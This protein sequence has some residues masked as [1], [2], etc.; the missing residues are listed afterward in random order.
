MCIG[1]KSHTLLIKSYPIIGYEYVILGYDFSSIVQFRLQLCNG[2]TS[3]PKNHTPLPPY[4]DTSS[5]TASGPSSPNSLQK[6][7]H[8]IFQGVIFTL[9]TY[10]I[11]Y[12]CGGQTISGYN[13]SQAGYD[14]VLPTHTLFAG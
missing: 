12:S 11:T 6:G 10:D 2:K 4:L 1:R 14:F 3:Y 7:Y 8:M 13:F 9:P 5:L